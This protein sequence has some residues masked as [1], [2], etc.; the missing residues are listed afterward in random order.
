MKAI[1]WYGKKDVRVENV[2]EPKLLTKRDAIVKTTLTAEVK[3]GG[4]T[5]STLIS[6]S[7][8]DAGGAIAARLDSRVPFFRPP[9]GGFHHATS[10]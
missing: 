1:C 8:H 7:D 5:N 3:A 4:R 9:T 2:A 6:R 10:S